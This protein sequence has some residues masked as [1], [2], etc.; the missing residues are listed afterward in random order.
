MSVFY[1]DDDNYTT[2]SSSRRS[3]YDDDFM[4]E[5]SDTIDSNSDSDDFDFNRF[6]AEGAS[7]KSKDYNYDD[8]LDDYMSE[9]A[10]E[11]GETPSA[12]PY[13][14]C[15]LSIPKSD[16]ID[17]SVYNKQLDQLKRTFKESVEIIE[18]IRPEYY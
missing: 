3:K 4:I 14:K 5:S 2:S 10:H 15:E 1:R 12:R 6:F 16:E 7:S 11:I 9:G 17:V 8:D 18:S 13:D